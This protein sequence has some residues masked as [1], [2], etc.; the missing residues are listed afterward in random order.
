MINAVATQLGRVNE[1]RKTLLVVSEGFETAPR[2]RRQ[3]LPTLSDAVRAAD[4]GNV[5]IYPIDPRAFLPASQALPEAGDDSQNVLQ[6]MAAQTSGA[7]ILRAAERDAGLQRIARD[8]SAFYVVTVSVDGR[9]PQG[10]FHPVEVRVKRPGVELRSRSGFWTAS[11]EELLVAELQKPR[12][13]K[14]PPG[15]PL[16]TSDF[17]RPWVGTIRGPGDL[18]RV[19]IVWEPAP[20]VLSGP[21]PP[22]EPD[23]IELTATTQD[24]TVVFQGPIIS[25][26]PRVA[27]ASEPSQAVFD[28][29]P[30]GLRLQM[31]IQ[32]GEARLLDTDVREIVVSPIQGDIA[33]G[34]VSL[35][36]ARTAREFRALESD[37]GAPPIAARQFSRSERLLIRVPVYASAAAP[38]VV[39]R[40]LNQAG[41]VM[42]EL[43]VTTIPASGDSGGFKQIDLPLAALASGDYSIELSADTPTTRARQTVAFRVTP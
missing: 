26:A 2:P 30:G 1:N 10:S 40:L 14:P 12:P 17:I 29:P 5:S 3:T 32:D 4:R 37:A 9:L 16:R 36:R 19:T 13:P 11:A 35:F 18:I 21:R 22:R 25:T 23:R 20:R 38:P 8:A 7:A 41:G 42:R 27:K 6:T 15:P 31:Q 28:V 33:F 34:A 24:G 43:V 39:A